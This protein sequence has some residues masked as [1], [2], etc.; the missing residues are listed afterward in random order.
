MLDELLRGVSVRLHGGPGP[1][2][3]SPGQEILAWF[4]QPW[5]AQVQT[6]NNIAVHVSGKDAFYYATFQNWDKA[7]HPVCTAVGTYEGCLTAG[8]QVWRWTEHT[9]SDAGVLRG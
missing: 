2:R 5:T 6:V 3:E 1:A 7:R 9:I 4:G 8:P